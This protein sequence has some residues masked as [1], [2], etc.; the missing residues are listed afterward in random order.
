MEKAKD[1]MNG[2]AQRRRRF[3]V[4]SLP[5][6]STLGGNALAEA[7]VDNTMTPPPDAAAFRVDFPRWLGSLSDRDRRLAEHLMLGVRTLAAARRFR[8]SPARVSQLRRELCVDWARI[9]GE[10]VVAVA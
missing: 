3:T 9:H 1:A 4:A 7:L 5:E 8:L 6:A 10:S 2:R